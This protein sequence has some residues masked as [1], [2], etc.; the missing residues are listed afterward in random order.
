MRPSGRVP[1]QKRQPS[2]TGAFIIVARA[3]GAERDGSGV[4]E[5]GGAAT[6]NVAVIGGEAAAR[7]LSPG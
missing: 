7:S 3:G 1:P 2:G 4:G 6:G 5:G